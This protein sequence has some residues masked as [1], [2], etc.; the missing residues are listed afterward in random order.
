MTV[1]ELT[2]GVKKIGISKFDA[3]SA[4]LIL[5]KGTKIKDFVK[6]MGGFINSSKAPLQK[7]NK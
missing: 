3:E 7:S 2:Q 4:S 5:S 1:D 6:E